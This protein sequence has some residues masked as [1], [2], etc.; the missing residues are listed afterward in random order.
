[1]IRIT[2]GFSA[3]NA[4]LAKKVEARDKTIAS[5][6][7]E[8]NGLKQQLATAR[9]DVANASHKLSTAQEE[10]E[11]AKKVANS[12][13]VNGWVYDPD[14]GWLFTNAKIYPSIYSSSTQSWHHYELG[15]DKPRLFYSYKDEQWEAWDPFPNGSKGAL[16]VDQGNK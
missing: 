15:S 16:A 12:P 2:F 11:A 13:F 9:E 14:Q 10:L 7:A 5:L 3:A 4:E 6:R 1:M 8:R